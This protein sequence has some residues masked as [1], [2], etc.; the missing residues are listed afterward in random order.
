MLLHPEAS[1]MRAHNKA[2]PLAGHPWDPKQRPEPPRPLTR[3]LEAASEASHGGL[4]GSLAPVVGGAHGG[5]QVGGSVGG[6][7][8]GVVL[9]LLGLLGLPAAW[10]MWH[11]VMRAHPET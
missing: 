9:A 8:V 5:G 2:I 11:D 10:M 3:S 1:R 6:K 7:V 4:R